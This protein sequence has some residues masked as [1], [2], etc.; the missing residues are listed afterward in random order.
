MKKET[1]NLIYDFPSTYEMYEG[2]EYLNYNR[3]LTL[4]VKDKKYHKQKKIIFDWYHS[5]HSLENN[6]N[7]KIDL[8]P[9]SQLAE[10]E[11]IEFQSQDKTGETYI[12]SW[13]YSHPIEY[14]SSAK[15]DQVKTLECIYATSFNF[16]EQFP[17]LEV[18]SICYSMAEG[19]SE[20]DNI[21][22]TCLKNLRLLSVEGN[23]PWFKI[24]KKENEFFISNLEGISLYSGSQEDEIWLNP[25][26]VLEFN[27]LK[28]FTKLKE[29]TICIWRTDETYD[30]LPHHSDLNKNNDFDYSELTFLESLESLSISG[31]VKNLNFLSGMSNL[32][33]LHLN[34]FSI[35]EK[36]LTNLNTLTN[37][38]TLR[39]N[40]LDTEI[41]FEI[42]NHADKFPN[43]EEIILDIG[44]IFQSFPINHKWFLPFKNIKK[45]K[46]PNASLF[47][48]E[49]DEVNLFHWLKNGGYSEDL[50]KKY[51][52]P[53]IGE[54]MDELS[55]LNLLEEIDTLI[56][57]NE[58][59]LK[60]F[61]NLRFVNKLILYE[62]SIEDDFW[63]I[64]KDI[65][66]TDAVI[67][68][69]NYFEDNS[70]ILNYPNKGKKLIDSSTK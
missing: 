65:E 46:F 45:I 40:S 19:S 30:I 21:N 7:E 62:L 55:E 6:I 57:K 14:S 41:I 25:P 20:S 70:A 17:N 35:T 11:E 13:S 67:G 69:V 54:T 63:N 49:G 5:F 50:I 53:L 66:I 15:L 33:E 1:D 56:L 36:L 31:P 51:N 64:A 37:F 8:A 61:K 27:F 34:E 23:Y 2:D 16:L 68:L 18:L 52:F 32:K 43:L 39:I 48:I 12:G 3:D 38:S 60:N 29:L 22:F 47:S 58:Q 4:L 28:I 44:D 26:S 24:N 59:S 10:L 42:S 9:L